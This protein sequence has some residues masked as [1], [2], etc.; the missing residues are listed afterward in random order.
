MPNEFSQLQ[1]M[2]CCLPTSPI[3]I[4]LVMHTEQAQ[5]MRELNK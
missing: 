3:R 5:L 4:R 1:N 2:F